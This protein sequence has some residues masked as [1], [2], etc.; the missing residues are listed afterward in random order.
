M[1]DQRVVNL[2]GTR[3]HRFGE[4]HQERETGEMFLR[5]VVAGLL[6]SLYVAATA[7]GASSASSSAYVPKGPA[8]SWDTLPAFFHCAN[9]SGPMS[10]ASIALMATFP[11]VTIE[12]F[13]GPCAQ[14]ASATPACDQE[15][16]IV[17]VLRRVKAANANVST[18]F[19]YNSVLD[20]PQYR[21]HATVGADPALQLRDAGGKPVK[22]SG[23]GHDGMDVFDFG[24]ARMRQLFIEECVNAT[25]TGFVDGCFADRAVDGTPTDSGDDT[26]PCDS[27]HKCRHSLNLSDATAHA[28]FAGHV[29]VLTELQTALGAGPLIANHAYGPPHDAMAAGTVSFAMIEGFGANNESINQLRMAAANGRGVQAHT[30]NPSESAFAAF[31]VGAGYR[32]YFGTGGWSTTTQAAMDAHR[33]SQFD[34]PL[35]APLADGAYDALSQTW[36]R[37]FAHVNASFNAKTKKGTVEGWDF[38]T[39]TPAPAPVPTPVPVPAPTAACPSTTA[40]GFEHGDIAQTASVSWGACCADCAATVGCA[41][42]TWSA[43]NANKKL[44]CHLHSAVATGPNTSTDRISGSMAKS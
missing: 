16:V 2:I 44:S 28:Y 40:G 8:F 39:P 25:R 22:M 21:L 23:G 32:A 33:P 3:D 41:H 5:S 10:E 34:L 9:S 17:D 37:R 42:W 36:T 12:K 38:P 14:G 30:M 1:R 35:G 20:F 4:P 26:V 15:A 31:L 24:S 18:I 29:Q 13:Q 43:N 6:L 19:Y 11:M 7:S 27:V